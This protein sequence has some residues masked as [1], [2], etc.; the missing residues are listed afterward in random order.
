MYLQTNCPT[1]VVGDPCYENTT[2]LRE[3][4][5]RILGD[6][7]SVKNRSPLLKSSPSLKYDDLSLL[8]SFPGLENLYLIEVRPK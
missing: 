3:S 8:K 4:F 5:S 7:L 2:R 6:P 1:N